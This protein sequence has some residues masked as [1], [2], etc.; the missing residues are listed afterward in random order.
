MVEES[1]RLTAQPA[2]WQYGVAWASAIVASIVSV[3]HIVSHF[4]IYTRPSQQRLIVRISAVIPIYAISSAL[5]LSCPE[6]VLYFAAVRDIAEAFVIY[7]FLTLLYDYLGGEGAIVNAINGMPIKGGWTTWTC[8]LTGMPFS[9]Q[10]LRFCKRV[11]LQFCLVRPL[12]S[13]MELVMFKVG[14]YDHEEA[15]SLHSAPLFVTFAYNISISLALYGLALFYICTKKLLESQRPLMK[16]VSVK[17]IILVSYWQNLL[18]A[19][20]AQHGVLDHPGAL[21]ALLTA[22]ET[23]PAAILVASAFPVGPYRNIS[24][25]AS[26]LDPAGFKQISVSMRDTV[27]PKDIL[28]DVVHNFSSRYRGYAQYHNVQVLNS[29]LPEMDSRLIGD[30]DEDH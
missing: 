23:I 10:I 27:N 26:P 8:C 29:N 28:E 6:Q 24:A 9:L 2:N 22:I 5:S 4:R 14:L 15:F 7:S 20:L 3:L 19:I 21:Q 18:I 11:T 12:V 13:I 25:D 16:F 30:S 1:G 17:G